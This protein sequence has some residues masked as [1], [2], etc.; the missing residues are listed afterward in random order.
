MWGMRRLRLQMQAADFRNMPLATEI[1]NSTYV[2]K[3]TN[4]YA[5]EAI[6]RYLSRS[7]NITFYADVDSAA[8]KRSY[9]LMLNG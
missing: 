2:H 6:I 5:V 9:V 4:C 1:T 8:S 3:T 7:T